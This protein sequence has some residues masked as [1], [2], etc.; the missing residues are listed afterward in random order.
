MDTITENP[1]NPTYQL[2]ADSQCGPRAEN[3]DNYLIINTEGHYQHLQNEAITTGQLK[4]WQADSVR[5]V[6]ADGMG[7]HNN[8][9]QVAEAVILAL[10]QLPFQTSP[11]QLRAELIKIHNQLFAQFHQGAKTPGSTLVMA[12]IG[13]DGQALIANIGD[14]RAYLY[15]QY[16]WK[17]LTK[18]HTV[19]EFAYRDQEISADEYRKGLLVNTNRI[20][21]AM[22]FGSSG[23]IPNSEGVKTPQHL[24]DLRI[25]LDADDIFTLQIK[26]GDV[27]M[28]VS[29]GLWSG[30]EKYT[31]DKINNGVEQYIKQQMENGL[32]TARDNIT[33]CGLAK[34]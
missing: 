5:L 16:N 9:R 23:I 6:I 30:V 12:D 31:P 19:L 34:P 29:D 11:K 8:G 13:P 14:S 3:Q 4:N 28:L 32:K 15:Q 25:D 33:L 2:Y 21:Q 26:T 22:S 1:T 10:L 7:G 24:P 20:V 18:D 17:Q 27:L